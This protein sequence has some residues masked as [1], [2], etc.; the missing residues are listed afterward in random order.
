MVVVVATTDDSVNAVRPLVNKLLLVIVIGEGLIK[1]T[2][3]RLTTMTPLPYFLLNVALVA[4]CENQKKKNAATQLRG[5]AKRKGSPL[6]T[7]QMVRLRRATFR[8]ILCSL[9]V[10]AMT[11]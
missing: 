7:A 1:T 8:C 4:S 6:G 2:H 10:L 5:Q 3:Q 9:I 11:R